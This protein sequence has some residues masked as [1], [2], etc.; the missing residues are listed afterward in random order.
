[1]RPLWIVAAIVCGALALAGV[2]SA[3]MRDEVRSLV[4]TMAAVALVADDATSPSPEPIP[5]APDAAT[6]SPA[7]SETAAT[8]GADD[9]TEAE[10]THGAAVSQ[11]ARDKAA[12][13]TKTLPSGKTITNHG[14][15]VSA[16]ARANAGT[17][18]QAGDGGA[19]HGNGHGN[20]HPGDKGEG[21]GTH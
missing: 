14:M 13:A 9:E 16:V 10:G 6:P 2:A 18:A 11:V 3:S 19:G 5:S 15:A 7:P 20:G 12:V 1:M 4:A 21:K 17:P 8:N